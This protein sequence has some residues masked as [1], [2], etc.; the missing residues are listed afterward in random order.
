M[1]FDGKSVRSFQIFFGRVERLH[2][3]VFYLAAEPAAEMIVRFRAPVEARRAFRRFHL[4]DVALLREQVQISVNGRLADVR[5]LA[6]DFTVY[7]FRVG[8]AE[9][10]HRFEHELPLPCVPSVHR[11]PN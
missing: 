2:G 10:V 1:P 9:P 6:R 8:M 5:V 7:F 11:T 3:G 4:P